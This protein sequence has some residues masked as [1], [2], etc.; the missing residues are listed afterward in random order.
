M[1][2][3][4]TTYPLD[5]VCSEVIVAPLHEPAIAS[6]LPLSIETSPAARAEIAFGWAT[7]ASE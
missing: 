4:T 6:R 7:R 5:D 1:Q 2:R 3:A